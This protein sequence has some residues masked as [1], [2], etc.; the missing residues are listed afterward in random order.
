[1]RITFSTRAPIAFDS[2]ERTDTRRWDVWREQG[3]IYAR[4]VYD[5]GHKCTCLYTVESLR[6]LRQEQE[7]ETAR[8]ADA[9]SRLRAEAAKREANLLAARPALDRIINAFDLGQTDWEAKVWEQ[10]AA[11]CGADLAAWIAASP[12]DVDVRKAVRPLMSE[13]KAATRE[14]YPDDYRDAD[15]KEEFYEQ[16]ADDIAAHI[17]ANI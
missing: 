4:E 3:R 7:R 12:R 10:I 16:H 13:A 6:E 5:S 17:A 15:E 2:T 11:E 1:M 8:R 9:T 14:D